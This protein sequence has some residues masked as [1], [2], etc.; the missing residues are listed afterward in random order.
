[1]TQGLRLKAFRLKVGLSRLS[2]H[3]VYL[4]GM[5]GLVQHLANSFQPKIL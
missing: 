1:M 3:L 5:G 2:G 4:V